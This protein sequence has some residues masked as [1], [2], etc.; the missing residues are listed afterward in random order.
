MRQAC[1]TFLE[2]LNAGKQATPAYVEDE[3]LYQRHFCISAPVSYRSKKP[4]ELKAM[5]KGTA[6]STSWLARTVCGSG[7]IWQH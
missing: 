5:I 6:R 2:Y 3:F 7:N 1:R 4:E